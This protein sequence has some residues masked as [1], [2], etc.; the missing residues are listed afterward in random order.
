MSLLLEAHSGS[1]FL[2]LVTSRGVAAGV[3]VAADDNV[4]DDNDDEQ[5]LQAHARTL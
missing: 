5:Q 3:T 2:L 4:D 1:E